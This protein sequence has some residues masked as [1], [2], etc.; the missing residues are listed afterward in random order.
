MEPWQGGGA[1][2]C[3]GSVFPA[4]Q[5]ITG[6]AAIPLGSLLFDGIGLPQLLLSTGSPLPQFESS[7][8]TVSEQQEEFLSFSGEAYVPEDL[9]KEYLEEDIL[10]RK[11]LSAYASQILGNRLQLVERWRLCV[12][13]SYR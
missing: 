5:L 11:G 13:F 2:W 3:I 6:A 10:L 7:I 1:P 9:L 12:I 4:P 8:P